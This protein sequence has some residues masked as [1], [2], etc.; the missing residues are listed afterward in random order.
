MR[1]EIDGLWETARAAW[2]NVSVARERF[3][4][5]VGERAADA[6]RLRAADLYLACGCLDGDSAALRAFAALLDEVGRKLRRLARNDEALADAKQV[7][8]QNL[9]ARGERSPALAEYSGRGE[10]GGWLRISLGRELV[11][12]GKRNE[13]EAPLDTGEAALVAHAAD[14]P[15]TA[16]LKAHYRLEFKAAFAA[17]LTALSDSEQ[18]VLRYSTVERLSIDEIARLEGVHRSTAGRDVA[19]A[20]AHLAERTRAALQEKL[21]VGAEQLESI[22]RLVPSQLDVSIQRLLGD[23]RG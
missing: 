22:L 1:P 4:A 17:A 6:T 11:R 14:D 20:R 18:R 19:R 5:F 3:A 21:Q 13:R 9:L 8:Q 16:Y 23:R 7:V 2:P 15:E 12:L 10:L